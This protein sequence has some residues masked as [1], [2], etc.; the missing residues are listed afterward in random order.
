MAIYLQGGMLVAD[1]LYYYRNQIGVLV[2]LSLLHLKVE[3]PPPSCEYA[4]PAAW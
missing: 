3:A 2:T 1:H 4:A